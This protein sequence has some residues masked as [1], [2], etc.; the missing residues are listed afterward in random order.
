M[1]KNG[2]GS[3]RIIAHLFL[4]ICC[5]LWTGCAAPKKDIKKEIQIPIEAR[6]TVSS[7][8]H[9]IK[10]PDFI[11]VTEN[12]SPLKTRFVSISA[13]NTQLRDVL[14]II[15]EAT[16][17]N[18]VMETGVISET[19]INMSIKNVSAEDALNT[20]FS[21]VDYF[22]SI[23]D[24]MLTVKATDTKMFEL[25]H[26]AITQTYNT[27][28]G[29]DILSGAAASAGGS[30]NIKGTVMQG[31]KADATAFDFWAAIEKSIAGIIM[32]YQ[33]PAAIQQSVTG[34]QGASTSDIVPA[35]AIQQSVTVNRLTGTIV[36]TGTKRNLERVE[37][38]LNTV[39]KVI[40]RQVMMEARIIE[41]QLSNDLKYGID[42]NAIGKTSGVG[43]INFGTTGLSSAVSATLPSFNIGTTGTNFTSL[44]KAL[45]QQGDVRTLSNPRIN[46]MNGQTSLLSV[47][48]T[49]NFVSKV[50]T[51]TTTGASPVTTYSVTTGNILS[52][53]VLGVVPYI[54][55]QGEISMTITP[56]ISDLVKMDNVSLGS[57]GQQTQISL[58]TVDL[59]ELSTTVKMRDGQMAV[60]G[61]LISKKESEQENR[62]PFLG[63]LPLIGYL[64]KSIDKTESRSELVI[65][66]RPVIISR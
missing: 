38:Y 63:S 39:K 12:V 62:V 10:M 2:I 25:G 61:G 23:K 53:I 7:S 46:I 65:M 43:D 47:G 35:A 54:N 33:P 1:V 24:N 66:L 16:S 51:S 3:G 14:H 5:L 60:I 6:E 31:T 57:S 29:G 42:W 45:Q 22:Y 58:P 52:G 55:D 11:P 37:Q 56:I 36:V 20:I 28:V 30:S 21:A 40:N 18:L 13:Q 34:T 48:R 32:A 17:M 49:T 50:E 4:T 64:F 15:S 27:D 19:P 44:L 41:V 59:K 9:E 8:T 26:P